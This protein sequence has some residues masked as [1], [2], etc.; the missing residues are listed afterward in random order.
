VAATYLTPKR[1]RTFGTGVDLSSTTDDQLLPTLSV[2]AAMVNAY[3][4]APMS[5]DFR[6]GTVTDEQHVWKLGN[7]HQAENQRIWPKHRPIRSASQLRIDVTNTQ[8]VTLSGSSLY[9]NTVENWV[10]PVAL[11]LSSVGL[12]NVAVLPNVGLRTPVAK[13]TYEYGWSFEAVDETLT[14]YSADG[15][16]QAMNQFWDETAPVVVTQNGSTLPSNQYDVDYTEGIVTVS[17]YDS[18]AMY[19]AS[20]T[21]TLPSNIAM[22]T[23]L[24]ASDL[25][26]QANI[27]AAGL[28][29]LSGIKVEEVELRQ[30]AKVG[31]YTT[32]INGAAQRLLAPYVYLSW[33]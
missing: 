23:A 32:P 3:C 1:F 26:G 18:T 21:Y 15:R 12:F 4:A 27:A 5:H 31:L 29:G 2:A 17:S 19:A 30:S 9:V 16:L 10:E 7:A 11:A 22:A 20:Y 14:T 33:G 13:L 24:V 25:L 6:G 28:L 8:Y